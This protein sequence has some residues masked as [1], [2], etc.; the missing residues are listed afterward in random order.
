MIVNRNDTDT[1][2][3]INELKGILTGTTGDSE[4]VVFDGLQGSSGFRYAQDSILRGAAF[5]PNK[6]FG[7]KS[8]LDV[9]EYVEN[10]EDVIG[11]VGVSWVGN[12]EDTTQLSFL[13]K[14]KIAAVLCTCPDDAFVMPYQANIMT[15]RYPLV[16][17]LYYIIKEDYTGLATG[18]ANFMEYERGQLIF[19]R[20]Y[21]G[22]AKM[23]FSI[24]RATES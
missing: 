24:R 9:I 22:P 3:T 17:G 2:Y 20:A 16:R 11:F 7:E 8:S 5:D 13:N 15:R 6:V 10:H 14:V 4:K 12:P 23:N 18:F 19:R 1:L 21:L